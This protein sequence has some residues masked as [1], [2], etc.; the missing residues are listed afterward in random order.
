MAALSFLSENE[1]EIIKN[2]DASQGEK[3]AVCDE[4]ERR[5]Q[6]AFFPLLPMLMNKTYI[7]KGEIPYV[8]HLS[9]IITSEDD[10]GE[11]NQ[12][13]FI[14]KLLETPPDT[15]YFK[16]TCLECFFLIFTK[17]GIQAVKDDVPLYTL[18]KSFN[19][20]VLQPID[21]KKAVAA[22]LSRIDERDE[23]F[24]TALDVISFLND[25]MGI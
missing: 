10:R 12:K 15:D 7:N 23:Q 3:Q 11:F 17:K 16:E 1:S 24:D 6:A 19:A 4:E 25:L 5:R 22:A 2:K 14:N 21:L 13:A 18:Y 9:N 8:V 20:A